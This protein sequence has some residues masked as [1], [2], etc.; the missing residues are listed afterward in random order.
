MFKEIREYFAY[1]GAMDHYSYFI[2]KFFISDLQVYLENRLKEV[3][4][5]QK[6]AEYI[7]LLVTPAKPTRIYMERQ[8]F[9]KIVDY[10]RLNKKL[11]RKIQEGQCRESIFNN[12][13]DLKK[14]ITEHLEKFNWLPVLVNNPPTI[15]DELWEELNQIIRNQSAY[16]VE[17]VR[18]GDN[19]DE[20]IS[21]KK[22]KLLEQLQPPERIKLLIEALEETAFIRTED[23]AVMSQS[24]SLLIPLYNEI[25][26][27]LGITY[28]ELKELLP[29]EVVQYL[30]TNKKIPK[31][32]IKNRLTLTCYMVY[33]GKRE[34]FVDKE[35][36]ELKE[37]FE[38]QQ[39][40]TEGATEFRGFVAS[41]GKITGKAKV[42]NTSKDARDIEPGDILVAPATSADF[43]PA[44]RKAGAIVTELGGLTSHAAVVARE[45]KLPCLVG[46][47]N[48]TKL[49]KNGDIV[50]VD[51][52][53][54]IIKKIIF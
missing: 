2:E 20:N 4:K 23:N 37:I 41:S 14:Q 27:R 11:V 35:A 29:E 12:D 49:L 31:N 50:E 42:C 34:V 45:F 16:S 15:L 48:I 51:A 6:L 1:N 24:S 19:Y 18:L 47:E 30:E 52:N 54:G 26:K 10:I 9:F 39:N 44:M 8:A 25:S 33:N 28:A 36:R 17:S 21:Q 3:K 38:T 32:L 22:K 46:V 7:A 53:N 13:P 43:V 5:E 40:V